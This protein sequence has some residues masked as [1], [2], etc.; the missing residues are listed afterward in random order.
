MYMFIANATRLL[1]ISGQVNSKKELAEKWVLDL[2]GN[3]YLCNVSK[4]TKGLSVEYGNGF[5]LV[6]TT[7]QF[8]DSIF[9]G[10]INGN[11]VNVKIMSDNKAG[12]FRLQFMGSDVNISIRS[13]RVSELE[14]YM[15]VLEFDKKITKL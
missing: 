2:N 3:K 8:G 6:E 4:T 1:S 9:R 5:S 14:K 10:K 7:W 11:L 15:P 12:D 13:T